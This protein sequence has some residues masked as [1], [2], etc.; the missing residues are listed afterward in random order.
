MMRTKKNKPQIIVLTPVRNEAWVLRAFLAATSLWAD[1]IIIA[2]Q[3]STDG[4]REIYRE[5][6]TSHPNP[7]SSTEKAD[8]HQ[9]EL[10]VIDNVLKEMHMAATRKLLFE[11]TQNVIKKSGLLNE[12]FILFAMDADEFLTGNFMD[13]KIWN[14]IMESNPDDVFCFRWKNVCRDQKC[15]KYYG[16]YMSWVEHAS[17]DLWGGMY[18]DNVIHEWRLPWS[19]KTKKEGVFRSDEISFIHLGGLPEKKIFHK[20]I[21][22]QVSTIAKVDYV[23]IVRHWRQY[24]TISNQHEAVYPLTELDFKIYKENGTDIF[25]LLN[26]EDEALHLKK[27]TTG[28]LEKFGLEKFGVLDIWTPRVCEEYGVKDPR[29]LGQ[30]LVHWY[31]RNTNKYSRSIIIRAIDKILKVVL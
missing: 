27:E 13:T 21:F 1:Y 31:C 6:Q 5:F 28:Y 8:V 11:A 4:S 16:P 14:Q 7:F 29:N 10:I 25:R 9:C 3:M 23:N 24:H 12:N 19:P 22:Y 18:P 17:D 20:N 30:K 15:F 2:D 26:L